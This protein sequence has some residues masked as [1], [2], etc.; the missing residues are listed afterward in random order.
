M[1]EPILVTKV[2]DDKRQVF[3]WANISVRKNGH[4]IRD[5][6]DHIIP[7]SELESAAYEFALSYR[8]AG[9]DHRT[10]HLSGKMIES[11]VVTKEK[12]SAM[13]LAPDAL[14]QG[15]WVGFQIDNDADWD[16][17]KKGDYRMFSIE[18][19]AVPEDEA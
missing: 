15:W 17:V 9:A 4:V 11:F 8:D 13:G 7:P 1:S 16:K 3:G 6:Q 12:L 19:V 14:P 5:W 18:G 2:D 10:G